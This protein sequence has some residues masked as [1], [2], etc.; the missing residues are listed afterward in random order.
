MIL[1]HLT[2]R[3]N[4]GLKDHCAVYNSLQ[5]FLSFWAHWFLHSIS[6]HPLLLFFFYFWIYVDMKYVRLYLWVILW[7]FKFTTVVL[8]HRVNLLHRC[9]VEKRMGRFDWLDTK[10]NLNDSWFRHNS[11]V[12]LDLTRESILVRHSSH[13]YSFGN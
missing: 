3:Q 5:L 8:I 6:H 7:A 11:I 2:L 12:C 1:F 10:R 9:W 13:I 4:P